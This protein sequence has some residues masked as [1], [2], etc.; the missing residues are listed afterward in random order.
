MLHFSRFAAGSSSPVLVYFDALVPARGPRQG[1]GPLHWLGFSGWR[2]LLILEGIP[3][4]LFGIVTSF[5]LTDRPKDARWLREDEKQ[6]ITSEIQRERNA[7]AVGHSD[8]GILRCV[9]RP[10]RADS[11][12]CVFF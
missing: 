11:G 3:A 5:Y 4:L 6:W 7:R 9:R 2:W 8:T 12:I 1:G 10:S